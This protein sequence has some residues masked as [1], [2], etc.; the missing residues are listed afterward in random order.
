MNIKSF[1]IKQNTETKKCQEDSTIGRK[2]QGKQYNQ[3]G[4]LFELVLLWMYVFV[5]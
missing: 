3:K 2:S 1:H 5:F 4:L